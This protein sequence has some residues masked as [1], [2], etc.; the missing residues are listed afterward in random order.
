M[1]IFKY[2]ISWFPKILY[3]LILI[4]VSCSQ[5]N[6]FKVPPTIPD[7]RNHV[8]KPASRNIHVYGEYFDRQVILQ[9]DEFF[10]LSRQYRNLTGTRKEAINVDAYGEVANSS[11]FTNRNSLK[12]MSDQ[13]LIRGPNSGSGPD[14]S[15]FWKITRAKVEGVTP[16]FSIQD[17]KGDNYP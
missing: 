17:K 3:L 14:K 15:G 10:D 7:D 12:K 16:G 6:I 8:P 1:R 13:E 2:K 9:F 5:N 11:W 4:L